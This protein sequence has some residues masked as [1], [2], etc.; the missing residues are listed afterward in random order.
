MESED[1]VEIAHGLDYAVALK[2]V[3]L[4]LAQIGGV[5]KCHDGPIRY[6]FA[7]DAGQQI[8]MMANDDVGIEGFQ[9]LCQPAGKR[10]LER[11]GGVRFEVAVAGGRVGHGVGHAAHVERH[12]V[13]AEP[14]GSDL[15]S[16]W[17]G[18][19]C[20]V[21]SIPQIT[22][23]CVPSNSSCSTVRARK[24]PL[25]VK[26][27]FWAMTLRIFKMVPRFR[28]GIG[29]GRPI[30]KGGRPKWKTCLFFSI[31]AHCVFGR[32]RGAVCAEMRERKTAKTIISAGGFSVGGCPFARLAACRPVLREMEK[33]PY[34]M[35]NFL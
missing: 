12:L 2:V 26:S 22:A 17:K 14:H 24:M 18:L 13:G 19:D 7:H 25:P 27:G 23:V 30:R 6:G 29:C 15:C 8:Q 31:V 32:A 35:S 33:N 21:V 20:L 4:H 3:L 1:A 34:I 5:A 9:G 11:S 10:R 28:F 16:I